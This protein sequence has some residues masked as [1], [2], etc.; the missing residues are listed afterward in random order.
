MLLPD[1]PSFQQSLADFC[2]VQ[3][4][5]LAA[6]VVWAT[7]TTATGIPPR[8]T[9]FAH[10][11]HTPSLCGRHAYIL[12]LLPD[13][14][15]RRGVGPNIG[16]NKTKHAA[17][18]EPGSTRRGGKACDS[19]E[20]T[21]LCLCEISFW[22]LPLARALR[23]VAT[24]WA[25]RPSAGE[26]SVRVPRRSPAAALSRVRPS[27]RQATSPIASLTPANVA[28]TDPSTSNHRL[29]T[30]SRARFRAVGPVVR[31]SSHAHR[32][33]LADAVLRVS[34]KTQKDVPCSRKS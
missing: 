7:I 27:V 19:S 1:V 2:A 16:R 33:A 25:N 34:L 24:H 6:G 22:R 4:S 26:S 8:D 20:G 9:P 3:K 13:F 23:P 32:A 15:G 30:G 29:I 10:Q 28:G 14:L 11:D 18:H 31:H 5:P 17:A 12:A 21:G